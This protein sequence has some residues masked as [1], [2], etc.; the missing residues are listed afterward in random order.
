MTYRFWTTSEIR[1]LRADIAARVPRKVTARKLSR[2][3][4][5]ITT[6]VRRLG[7]MNHHGQTSP[8]HLLLRELWFDL[9]V[10]RV[11]SSPFPGV[12]AEKE[13]RWRTQGGG[14]P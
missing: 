4:R 3:Y 6:Q 9:S 12:L 14:Y 13:T 1:I 8:R 5:G 11:L 2:P 7:L 10:S